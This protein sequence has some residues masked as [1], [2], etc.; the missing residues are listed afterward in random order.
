MSNLKELTAWR[1]HFK[2]MAE[3]KLPIPSDGIY[4]VAMPSG[5]STETIQTGDGGSTETIKI[6][7]PLEGVLEQAKSESKMNEQADEILRQVK[8]KIKI[9]KRKRTFSPYWST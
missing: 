3:Q 5:G 8:N 6:I 1:N 4:R 9:K 7:S 2:A